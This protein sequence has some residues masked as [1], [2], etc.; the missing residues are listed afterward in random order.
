MNKKDVNVASY[1]AWAESKL[2]P[3]KC[4]SIVIV[5][6]SKM[7]YGWYD[8]K[9]TIY[10]NIKWCK[11]KATLYRVLAHEWTHAQQ[12]YSKYKKL[13]EIYGYSEHPLEI[14]AR[15][16]ERTCHSANYVQTP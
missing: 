2:G 15:R 9:G 3:S 13:M 10:L 16:R 14:E 8:W 11:S 7:L 4:K 1:A 12:R 6:Q 5:N